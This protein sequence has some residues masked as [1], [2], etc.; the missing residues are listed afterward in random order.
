MSSQYPALAPKATL[1]NGTFPAI[2]L[3]FYF[4]YS[5]QFP[6][7]PLQLTV[8]NATF[9]ALNL[10]QYLFSYESLNLPL[11]PSISNSSASLA[12]ILWLELSKSFSYCLSTTLNFWLYQYLVSS[13]SP[14]LLMKVSI[15]DSKDP[16]LNFWIYFFSFPSLK[17]NLPHYQSITD[18]P[19]FKIS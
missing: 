1:S 6:A 10:W 2:I 15:S 8:S 11:H 19:S 9:R 4:I 13:W 5:S 12:L 18:S 14:T 16:A 3:S 7:L 17:V